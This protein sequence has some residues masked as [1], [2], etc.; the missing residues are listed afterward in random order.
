MSRETTRK[1]FARALRRLRADRHV[2]QE[3]VA[4]AIGVTGAAVSSWERET[5][6]PTLDN[7]WKLADYFGVSAAE[8]MGKTEVVSKE[9][10]APAVTGDSNA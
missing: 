9:I 4:C 1:A 6:I 7:V 2:R 10:I 5:S 8:V 3:D